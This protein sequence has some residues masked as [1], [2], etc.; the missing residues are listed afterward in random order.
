MAKTE[1]VHVSVCVCVCVCVQMLF[2]QL[3]GLLNCTISRCG[4]LEQ[5]CGYFIAMNKTLA[6]KISRFPYVHIAAHCWQYNTRYVQSVWA[7]A[8][9]LTT[10]KSLGGTNTV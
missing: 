3:S 7:A 1:C 4:I 8:R 5:F 2:K 6:S 10:V 9:R